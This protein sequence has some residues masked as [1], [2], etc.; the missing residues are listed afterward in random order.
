M[1]GHHYTPFQECGVEDGEGQSLPQHLPA[2]PGGWRPVPDAV[3][4]AL[5]REGEA[6]PAVKVAPPTPRALSLWGEPSGKALN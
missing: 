5:T 2:V 4:A 3:L 6:T 1:K